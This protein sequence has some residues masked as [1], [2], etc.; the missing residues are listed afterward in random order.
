MK[1]RLTLNFARMKGKA[2]RFYYKHIICR[3][4]PRQKWLTKIIPRTF[5]DIDYLMEETVFKCLINFWEHDDGEGVLRYQ[6]ECVD[7]KDEGFE[8]M[9]EQYNERK[10][11]YLCMKEA[12]DH[13]KKRENLTKHLYTIN[14]P[15]TYIKFKDHLK[16]SDTRH[17]LNIIRY[18]KYLWS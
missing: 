6:W 4:N 17:L 11:V 1:N 3:L 8:H 18:R 5:S 2:G 14:N 9:I 10:Q 13:A 7:L 15:K 16:E 12:Y